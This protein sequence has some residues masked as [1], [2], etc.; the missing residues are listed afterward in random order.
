MS[1]RCPYCGEEVSSLDVAWSDEAK[2]QVAF[3]EINH[4]EKKHQDIIIA[5]LRAAGE[6]AAADDRERQAAV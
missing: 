1:V 4:M 5:R 6:H 3:L 2:R